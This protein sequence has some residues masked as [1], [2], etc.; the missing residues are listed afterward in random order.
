MPVRHNGM[1]SPVREAGL[2][3]PGLAQ[4]VPFIAGAFLAGTVTLAIS[5][6]VRDNASATEPYRTVTPGAD[7]ATEIT[8]EGPDGVQSVLVALP[9]GMQAVPI[10]LKSLKDGLH[11]CQDK[12][13]PLDAAAM[14]QKPEEVF[15]GGCG[16]AN[17]FQPV[18]GKVS[19]VAIPGRGVTM[20]F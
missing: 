14:L 4:I 12:P 16:V 11:I 17:V 3:R 6:F 5:N 8:I 2:E 9:G 7:R 18:Q 1:S 10:G 19:P 15:A 13:L 20:H